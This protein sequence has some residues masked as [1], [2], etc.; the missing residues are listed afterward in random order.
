MRTLHTVLMLLAVVL[1]VLTAACGGQAAQEEEAT[2]APAAEEEAIAEDAEE[3]ATAEDEPT[4]IIEEATQEPTVETLDDDVP[5]TNLRVGLV[6]DVGQVNDGTFNE[7]AHEGAQAA[8]EDYGLTYSYIET[9]NPGDYEQNIGTLVEEEYDIIVTVGFLIADDTYAAAIDHPGIVFIG[10]DQSFTG[11]QALPNLIGVQFREDQS[12]FLVGALAGMMTESDVVGFVG[13]VDV[14]AVKKFRFGYEHGLNYVNPD[15]SLLSVYVPSFTDPAQGASAAQQFVGEGADVI[16]GAGGKTGTGAIQEAAQEGVYVI[17][18]D[19]DEYFTTFGGG[20]TPGSD[21]LLTSAIKRVDV[22]VY[23]QIEAVVNG[24]FE[25]N[26]DYILDAENEGIGYADFHETADE[27]PNEAKERLEEIFQM[28]ADG[29][30]NT[31]V[32]PLSGEPI[33]EEIPEPMPFEGS[34]D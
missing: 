20:E 25:G 14:P 32:D 13:G 6:T 8:V 17:G 7:F 28:L 24:T 10:V 18:V 9:Q 5:R 21:Q 3:E 33:P 26:G 22:G 11:E 27:I 15:A 31:G 4:E 30:L 1:M 12:G 23:D 19:Q 34:I 16:F 2:E 29:E